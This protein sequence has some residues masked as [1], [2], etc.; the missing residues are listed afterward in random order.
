MLISKKKVATSLII[1]VIA[2]FALAVIG[3]NMVNESGAMEVA[4]KQFPDAELARWKP[5]TY[6]ESDMTGSA[7]FTLCSSQNCQKVEMTKE[8]GAWI[9]RNVTKIN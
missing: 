6:G 5:F 2:A 7:S 3:Q 8:H 9:I 4:R 1:F